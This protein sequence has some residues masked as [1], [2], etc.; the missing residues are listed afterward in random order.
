MK[1]TFKTDTGKVRRH[2]EDDGGVFL[3]R[4][5]YY[6][7]VVADGMGGHN[8]GEVASQMAVANLQKH[9][10]EIENIQTP[11]EAENWLRS[12]VT[13]INKDIYNHSKSNSELDGM[14]TTLVAAICTNLFATIVNIGD[15]R[16]YI[17]NED[18]FKQ[19]TEDHS[20]VN[21]LIKIGHISPEDAEI[22]PRKNMLLKAVGTEPVT[23]MDIITITF[24]E[25][26]KLLL[27]SDGLSNKVTN[28]ELESILQSDEDIDKKALTMINL[29]NQNGGEDNISVAIIETCK[30][31]G[32]EQ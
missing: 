2:N 13:D 4:S 28:Q 26:D 24:E 15:S 25:G 21:E 12:K 30:E 29:A 20:L 7:A 27:C 10:N 1:A 8:A 11:E 23:E 17:L 14:G 6:L 22:H 32:C 5:G 16:C 31:S 3:H 9:W 19:L 18:G